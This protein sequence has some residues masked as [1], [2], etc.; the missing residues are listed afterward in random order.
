M[1]SIEEVWGAPFPSRKPMNQ[2][3]PA[4]PPRDAHK[5]GRVYKT[6]VDRSNAAVATHRKTI[7]DLSRTLPIVITEEDA[8]QNFRPYKSH[9]REGFKTQ[10]YAYSPPA[11]QL[12]EPQDDKLNRI[13]KMV[14]QN[15]TGYESGSTQ[16]ML[17]Y[18]FTG[19]FF[20]YTL[21]TFVS[22][23]KSMR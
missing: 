17:L 12:K 5:E 19:I 9:V 1:A 4:E 11:Y 21:D 22:L 23:G 3:G 15:K 8:S 13:L 10:E 20:L 7:D 14:E 6:P 16:D 18:I 2:K